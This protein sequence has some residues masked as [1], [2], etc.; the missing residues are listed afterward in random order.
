MD[1]KNPNPFAV[2]IKVGQQEIGAPDHSP[3][4]AKVRCDSCD[5]EFFIAPSQ[6]IGPMKT[7]KDLEKQLQT[8]LAEDHLLG[9]T[10][11]S[12]YD[13]PG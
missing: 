4:L 3:T 7:L 9:S 12:K 1:G 6:F 13:L 11:G 5:V 2:A 8:M 10:H